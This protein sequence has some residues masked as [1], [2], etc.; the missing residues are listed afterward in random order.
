ML[1]FWHES[2]RNPNKVMFLRYEEVKEDASFWLKKLAGFLGFPFSKEEEEEGVV[3]GIVKLCSFEQMKELDVNKN[4]RGAI[5]DF[6]NKTL[7]RR[8]EVGD[9]VNYFTPEMVERLSKI[10]DQNLAASGLSFKIN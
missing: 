6:E 9:W 5:A 1:G 3:E 10:M 2:R 8:G 7:F 4:G